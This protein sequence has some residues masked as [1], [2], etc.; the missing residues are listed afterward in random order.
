MK[1]LT[2]AL[3][4]CLFFLVLGAKWAFI[5]VAG[6]DMPDWD[7]WDAEGQNLIIPW[8]EHDHFVAHLFEPHNEHRVVVTKLQ[9]LAV[10]LLAGQW[11][12]RLE[13][14]INALLHTGLAVAFFIAGC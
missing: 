7:Q 3:A 2:A 4:V 8:F 12:G 9:N 6:S 14:V 13:S 5:D 11:D 1:R 10:T